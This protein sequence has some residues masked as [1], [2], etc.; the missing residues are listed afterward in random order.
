MTLIAQDAREG[1]GYE[2]A[3]TLKDLQE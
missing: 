2:I 3:R 1:G